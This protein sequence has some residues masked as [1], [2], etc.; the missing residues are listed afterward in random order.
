MSI[1]V[2]PTFELDE[3]YNPDMI[4][5]L[6]DEALLKIMEDKYFTGNNEHQVKSTLTYL[7]KDK[8]CGINKVLE[9]YDKRLTN[10]Y[11][12]DVFKYEL[13]KL[14]RLLIEYTCP[15]AY[16]ERD[17]KIF[18]IINKTSYRS[19][20]DSLEKYDAP[21]DEIIKELKVKLK[22]GL[23]SQS[24]PIDIDMFIDNITRAQ[25]DFIDKTNMAFSAAGRIITAIKNPELLHEYCKI[26]KSSLNK[27]IFCAEQ[28]AENNPYDYSPFE[29]FYQ[30]VDFRQCIGGNLSQI[31]IS[32][33]ML[34][35]ADFNFTPIPSEILIEFDDE[36]IKYDNIEN[37]LDNNYEK[38][39]YFA[40]AGSDKNINDWTEH[41]KRNKK[42][43]LDYFYFMCGETKSDERIKL[44]RIVA[45][46]RALFLPEDVG[47]KKK[48]PILNLKFNDPGYFYDSE[49]RK[50]S[51]YI[52]PCKKDSKQTR[53]YEARLL[54]EII[55]TYIN[56]YGN[57]LDKWKKKLEL[58]TEVD[59]AQMAILNKCDYRVPKFFMD[60]C[61]EEFVEAVLPK[62]I[63]PIIFRDKR[64]IEELRHDEWK[65]DGFLLF[66]REGLLSQ[67]YNPDQ[68]YIFGNTD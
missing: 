26:F 58:R 36:D 52:N 68:E 33:E 46:C 34:R 20:G 47:T 16:P 23:K 50:K 15:Y 3:R 49:K 55:N 64:F 7:L 63:L 45:L 57:S 54:L 32:K 17:Y 35:I 10:S 19:I 28:F 24:K 5:Y 8:K 4:K 37:Y 53:R 22:K 13:L 27:F 11:G 56:I 1:S 60:K 48:Q 61:Y 44:I 18:H 43:I 12:D 62:N 21:Q 9:N 51:I 42:K 29:I 14:K 31:A 25:N 38:I 6:G 30:V 66:L 41:V 67:Y 59:M 40:F 2:N 39:A 65:L